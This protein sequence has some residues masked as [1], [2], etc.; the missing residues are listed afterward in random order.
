MSS[1]HQFALMSLQSLDENYHEVCHNYSLYSAT[2]A[3]VSVKGSLLQYF[4]MKNLMFRSME[5][6]GNVSDLRH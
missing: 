5:T 2:S 3:I 1:S 4:D 6:F